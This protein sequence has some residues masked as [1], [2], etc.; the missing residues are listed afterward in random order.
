MKKNTNITSTNLGK[1]AFVVAAALSLALGGGAILTARPA[2]ALDATYATTQQVTWNWTRVASAADA[3]QAVGLARFGVPA[4]VAIRDLGYADPAFSWAGGVAQATYE[5]GATALVVRKAN[6]GA[7]EAPL[8]DRTEAEFAWEYEID[9]DGLRLTAL[10]NTQDSATVI[11]WKDGSVEYG[12]TWQG[13]GGEEMAMS[14]DDAARLAR[15][16]RDAN[17]EP[18]RQAAPT[19]TT[20]QQAPA[21]QQAQP[22]E[23]APTSG[24]ISQQDAIA[25]A[26]SYVAGDNNVSNVACELSSVS[27]EPR[28]VVTFHF[29]DA[30]Y[31]VKVGARDGSVWYATA[32]FNDG[33]T[34][35]V[36]KRTDDEAEATSAQP[37]Q[38]ETGE[39][40]TTP[41]QLQQETT[42]SSMIG[43]GA[44]IDAAASS[45]GCQTSGAS[46]QLVTG[47]DAPHY[48]VTLNGSDGVTYTVSV[49][50]YT[51]AVWSVQPSNGSKAKATNTTKGNDAS[52]KGKADT[53]KKGNNADDEDATYEDEDG[54]GTKAQQQ[55][56]NYDDA[57]VDVNIEA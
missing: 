55:D 21:Q 31:L 24:L 52:A 49:D 34:S 6:I 33:T 40:E 30:D 16:I 25:I 41:T 1:K 15:T 11:T 56:T 4:Q 7:H 20:Q 45:V 48:V 14:R 32:I 26:T 19:Q 27:T 54:E 8:T 38:G 29:D 3:A 13:L 12:I 44:A 51:G 47:G 42:N 23:S 36:T 28:Y 18:Q 9:V 2:M 39:A 35:D 17:A 10:G 57:D 5:T 50:A 22:Q 53:T 37:K 46:A 43:S